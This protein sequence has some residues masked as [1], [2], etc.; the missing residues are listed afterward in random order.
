MIPQEISTSF[1]I[2]S[3]SF[4]SVFNNTLTPLPCLAHYLFMKK[5][6]REI[7]K[8]VLLFMTFPGGI[9]RCPT[10]MKNSDIL[11]FSPFPMTVAS[12]LSK[13]ISFQKEKAL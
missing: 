6:H 9:L 7:V 1:G 10:N 4:V 5:S 2:T 3:A 12:L 11:L 8:V 13:L